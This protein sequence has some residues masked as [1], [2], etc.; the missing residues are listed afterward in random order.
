MDTDYTDEPHGMEPV[1]I[2]SVNTVVNKVVSNNIIKTLY[3]QIAALELRVTAL[4][5]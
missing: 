2:L 3:D 5:P 1:N 4:E